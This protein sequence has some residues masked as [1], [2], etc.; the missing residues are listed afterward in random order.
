M[1][2][3]D[4]IFTKLPNWLRWILALPVAIIGCLLLPILSSFSIHLVV[5]W[6]SDGILIQTI[7]M[8]ASISGFMLGLFFCIPKYKVIITSVACILMAIYLSIMIVIWCMQGYVWIDEN[9][10][11]G[12]SVIACIIGGIWLLLNKDEVDTVNTKDT[13][14]L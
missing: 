1:N 14:N 9:I 12:L 2:E 13:L 7:V 6:D 10:V 11:N 8:L 5:G 4:W 3:N